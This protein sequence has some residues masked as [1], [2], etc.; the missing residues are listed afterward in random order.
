VFFLFSRCCYDVAPRP[1]QWIIL[2][3]FFESFSYML[4]RIQKRD[5]IDAKIYHFFYKKYSI[6]PVCNS[7][8]KNIG[9]THNSF[10]ISYFMRYSSSFGLALKALMVVREALD[11]ANVVSCL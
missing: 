2:G 1:E 7:P 10:M 11:W 4:L 3:Y 8:F 9:I 5:R 6:L